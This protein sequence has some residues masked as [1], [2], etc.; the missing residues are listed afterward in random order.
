MTVTIKRKHVRKLMSWWAGFNAGL[1]A[2]VVFGVALG[3]GNT[4]PDQS[5]PMSTTDAVLLWAWAIELVVGLIAV[6]VLLMAY[7]DTDEG[8]VA[9]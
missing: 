5:D 3:A 6:W 1:L 9:P 8:T 4:S 2:V 7:E